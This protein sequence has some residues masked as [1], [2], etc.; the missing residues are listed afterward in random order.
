MPFFLGVLCASV[1]KSFPSK[2]ILRG[3]ALPLLGKL[4]DD[5]QQERLVRRRVAAGLIDLQ[6]GQFAQPWFGGRHIACIM[7]CD[8]RVV[9][10]L[11]PGFAEAAQ[12][13][14]GVLANR[15]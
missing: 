14:E 2:S 9:Y 5:Q 3:H 1:V 15:G 12:A 13:M 11:P 6:M 10:F 4:Q 7:R 8:G